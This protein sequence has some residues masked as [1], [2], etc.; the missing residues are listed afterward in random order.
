MTA[1]VTLY[2]AI[3][4]LHIIAVFSA[5]GLPAAWPLVFPYLHR[6]HPRAIPGV[7]DIQHKLT[8]VLTGPGTVALLGFGIYLATKQH[9]WDQPYVHVG[10]AA[11]VIIGVAGGGIVRWTGELAE[12]SAAALRDGGDSGTLAFGARYDA[13]Y[14]RYLATE[15]FLAV[16]VLVTIFVMT[17][18]P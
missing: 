10:I 6:H 2:L 18:K 8:I 5:Y 15:A 3:K 13:V 16:V 17:T 1:S 9:Q 14:R 12:L 7:H 11:L 4:A